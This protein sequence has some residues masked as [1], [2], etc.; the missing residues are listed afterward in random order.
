MQARQRA[1]AAGDWARADELRD[2]LRDLGWQVRDGA[3]GPE[4]LP[5]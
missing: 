4:L 3:D 2:Q 1:R 5:A